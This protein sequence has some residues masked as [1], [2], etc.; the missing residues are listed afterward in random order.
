MIVRP[1]HFLI[2]IALLFG[3]VP[4]FAQPAEKWPGPP[5]QGDMYAFG[6][7]CRLMGFERVWQ[8][9]REHAETT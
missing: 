2:A 3:A 1:P 6:E 9:E 7:F 8:F 4:G 5:R